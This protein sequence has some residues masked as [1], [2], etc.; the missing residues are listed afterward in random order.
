PRAQSPWREACGRG[1]PV[2]LL[3]L[4]RGTAAPLASGL[5]ARLRPG[6]RCRR[7][8]L[9]PGPR[10]RPGRPPVVVPRLPRPH[11][12]G[13]APRVPR[14]LP[15]GALRRGGL[16]DVSALLLLAQTVQ[17]AVRVLRPARR[18]DVAPG[19]RGRAASRG[20]PAALV[21]VRDRRGGGAG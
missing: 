11:R 16:H 7:G 1:L 4:L 20:P 9:A 14:P 8:R 15:H 10:P 21:V 17:K 18:G 12:G 2:H 3:P 5:A 6:G 19:T 13:A